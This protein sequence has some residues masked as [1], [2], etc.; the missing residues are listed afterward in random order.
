[1]I[2]TSTRPS[3][4]ALALAVIPALLVIGSCNKSETPLCQDAQ[5][6]KDAVQGLTQVDF[7]SGGVAALKSAVDNVR[8]AI[9]A[10]GT[11]A[12]NT[13]GTQIDAVQTQLTA[14][15]GAVDEVQGGTPVASVAPAVRASLSDL[16]TTL[17]S[18]KSTAQ[19]QNCD[20]Q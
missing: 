10:L 5:N 7:Q 11:E 8:S 20:L 15:G 13:F 16:K 3:G 4:R 9:D 6:L 14:L 2:A 12:R 17:S 18:L 19:S 1:M